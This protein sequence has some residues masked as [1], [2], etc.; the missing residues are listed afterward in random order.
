MSKYFLSHLIEEYFG[1]KYAFST[2]T[3]AIKTVFSEDLSIL[4]NTNTDTILDSDKSIKEFSFKC[5]NGNPGLITV[6]KNRGHNDHNFANSNDCVMIPR[7]RWETMVSCIKQLEEFS[8]SS[9][10]MEREHINNNNNN[11]NKIGQQKVKYHDT[12]ID[13]PE[14]NS[15]VYD[16]FSKI[17]TVSELEEVMNGYLKWKEVEQ[18]DNVCD[19]EINNKNEVVGHPSVR[20]DISSKPGTDDLVNENQVVLA[21]EITKSDYLIEFNVIH[22]GE[23]DLPSDLRLAYHD[24][25]IKINDLP[26]GKHPLK[27]GRNKTIKCNTF[28][29][30]NTTTGGVT[31]SNNHTTRQN[32]IYIYDPSDD[33]VQYIANIATPQTKVYLEKAPMLS[34]HNLQKYEMLSSPSLLKEQ[35]NNT[36]S[37]SEDDNDIISTTVTNTTLSHNPRNTKSTN[38]R[39]ISDWEDYEL[40]SD[41][42]I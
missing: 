38:S 26:L 20:S 24:E 8:L 1:I 30:L 40:L 14:S 2:C 18:R 39:R 10:G 32:Y 33:S 5:S 42:D 37:K 4:Q 41:S 15:K 29:L 9:N 7:S 31:S 16:F 35:N 17:E 12:I 21:V 28:N 6:V 13:I 34:A 11:N 19:Q 27:A 3:I 36:Q 25:S 23:K 22:E